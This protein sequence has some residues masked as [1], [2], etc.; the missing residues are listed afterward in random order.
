MARVAAAVDL[1]AAER[2]CLESQV[3]WYKVA[4]SLSDRCHI[5]LL[6]A[7]GLSN[8]DVSGRLGL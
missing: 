7:E 3:R 1:R 4:R 5:V 8:K 6:C 2:T